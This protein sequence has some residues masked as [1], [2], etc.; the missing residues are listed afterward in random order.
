MFLE[1][2][3]SK[4]YEALFFFADLLGVKRHQR[5][6]PTSVS[7]FSCN[8]TIKYMREKVRWDMLDASFWFYM[9]RVGDI[10]GYRNR[11]KFVLSYGQA[12]NIGSAFPSCVVI[13]FLARSARCI[14][15]S[16]VVATAATVF[17][18]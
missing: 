15:F 4:R 16:L 10:N 6:F 11:E 9:L 2:T 3:H 1:Y 13:N 8:R 18:F 12:L 5:I 14:L 7:I 17:S